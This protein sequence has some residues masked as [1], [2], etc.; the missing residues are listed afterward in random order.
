VVIA[1]TVEINGG[2][3]LRAERGKREAR[4][5]HRPLRGARLRTLHSWSFKWA[6]GGRLGPSPA[7]QEAVLE[8]GGES[9]VGCPWWASS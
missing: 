2:T 6:A 3:G 8:Q 4:R 7:L 5:A 9:G 1:P